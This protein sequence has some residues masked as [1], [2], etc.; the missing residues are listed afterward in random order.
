MTYRAKT[1]SGSL[2]AYI[3]TIGVAALIC[4]TPAIA[5][6]TP[7][8]KACSLLTDAEI[9]AAVGAPSKSTENQMEVTQ[10]PAKGGT[11]RTCT[12]LIPTGAVNLSLMKV[13]D[14]EAAR[15]AFRAQMQ[16]TM[17][18]LK[19]KGWTIEEKAFGED[20]RCWIGTPPASDKDTPRATGC[21]GA[22]NGIGISVGT[23]GS[24]KVEAD[25]V[26]KLL[27]AAMKRLG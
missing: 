20:A 10:G 1:P 12:W 8:D 11:V 18:A 16:R 26:K 27:D 5:R 17:Q 15:T 23:T 25:A 13:G 2:C 24:A 21:V 4:A 7:P 9:T 14:I 19:N 22:T 3:L 6:A